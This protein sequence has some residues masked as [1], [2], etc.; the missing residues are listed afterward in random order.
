MPAWY[1]VGS[2]PRVLIN[3]D[4]FVAQGINAAWQGPF[5]DAVINAYT[6]WMNVAGVDV[7]PQF[8]GYTTQLP[9]TNQGDLL[10]LMTPW[11]GGGAPNIATTLG[12]WNSIF[13]E[14]HRRSGVNGS[15]WN[16]VPW[17]AM[18][19]QIDMQAVALHELGHALGLDHSASGNDAMFPFYGYPYRYGPFEGDVAPLKA[20]YPDYQQNRLRQLRSSDGAATWVPVPNELTSHPHWHTRT[21]QSPGVAAF[22]GSGLYVLG[23]THSNRIPTWLRNDG[24]KFLTRLWYYFGGERTVHG[25][26]YA[27]D[28]RGTV[29]WARVT[30][31]DSGALRLS[32]SRNHG[33]SWF[34]AG[35]AGARTAGTPGLAWTRVAG[36]SCWVLVWA[37]FNRSNDAATGQ[38]RASTS[39]DDGA[40]WSAPTVLHPTLKALSGVSVAASDTNRLMVALAFANTAGTANLNEIVT[41]PAAVVG[42]QLQA[43]AP[44]FTGERTRIQPAL[45]YDRARDTFVLAWREQNFNTTLGVAVLP[46][47]APAW[48]GRVWLLAHASHVAPALASS[49]E[50]GETVL[51]YAHE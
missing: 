19:G 13:I 9:P 21:N 37:D 51:W 15:L 22:R 27:S 39:F 16:F 1:P 31:D 12:G 5:T 43:S 29:L 28:D 17:N 30:N 18:P 20:L 44:V 7:R 40:T 26:A 38:V 4:T 33:R 14:F 10:I 2:R 32:V 11:H 49:P 34:A 42:Q 45:A 3:W 36:Q 23:W 8:F 41:V 25:P 6:R 50:L 48:S 46:P 47:G 35:L 24:E